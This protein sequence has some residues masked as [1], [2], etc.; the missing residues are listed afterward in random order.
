MN[1]YNNDLSFNE[2]ITLT[3]DLSFINESNQ[4]IFYYGNVILTIKDNFN[5]ASIKYLE[6]GLENELNDIIKQ[7]ENRL[8]KI[9]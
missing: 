6:N 9:N 1:S 7:I 8:K 4:E 2:L 3:S 5:R